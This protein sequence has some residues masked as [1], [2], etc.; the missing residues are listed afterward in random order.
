MLKNPYIN[1]RTKVL[2]V[3]GHPIEHSMS[4]FMHNAALEELSL[5]YIYLAFD[6]P[7]KDLKKA[8]LGFK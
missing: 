2:C 3:I 1:T 8:V 4:P 6:V 5:D 7:P